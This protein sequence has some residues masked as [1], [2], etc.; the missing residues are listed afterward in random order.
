MVYV[1]I[2][3]VKGNDESMFEMYRSDESLKANVEIK[4]SMWQI[5]YV[6]ITIDVFI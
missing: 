2:V 1:L 6:R 3:L 4:F 5:F